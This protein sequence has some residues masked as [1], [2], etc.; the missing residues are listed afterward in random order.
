MKW[1]SS[2]SYNNFIILFGLVLL[3]SQ[4]CNQHTLL[5]CVLSFFVIFLSL[6][7][8]ELL[9]DLLHP[10]LSFEFFFPIQPLSFHFLF[11]FPL[12]ALV[13]FF[14]FLFF[15]SCY[16]FY[17]LQSFLCLSPFGLIGAWLQGKRICDFLIVSISLSYSPYKRLLRFLAWSS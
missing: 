15:V 9:F 2:N 17:Q 11:Q 10:L 14:H 16:L 8:V 6:V 12:K 1:R 7:L 13:F 3:L 4:F 5:L